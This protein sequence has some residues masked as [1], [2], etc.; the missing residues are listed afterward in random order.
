V[1]EIISTNHQPKR[2]GD[3]RLHALVVGMVVVAV[4]VAVVVVVV[5]VVVVRRHGFRP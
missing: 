2:G 4:V 3:A 1:S 5:V